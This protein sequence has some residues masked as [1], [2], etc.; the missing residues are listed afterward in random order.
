MG[1][2]RKLQNWDLADVTEEY[3]RFS[4]PK[5]RAID[6][7]CIT[8]FDVEPVSAIIGSCKIFADFLSHGNLTGLE[9]VG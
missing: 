6:E 2:L 9:C 3:R 8:R 5:S 4:F 7:Q 1:C